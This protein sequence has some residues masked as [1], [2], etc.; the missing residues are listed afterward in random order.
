MLTNIVLGKMPAKSK[1]LPKP[2]GKVQEPEVGTAPGT[3]WGFDS[4]GNLRTHGPLEEPNSYANLGIL[5]S[6]TRGRSINEG[7]GVLYTLTTTLGTELKLGSKLFRPLLWE[8][9]CDE[10]DNMDPDSL[11]IVEGIDGFGPNEIVESLDGRTQRGVEGF[12]EGNEY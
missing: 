12:G 11:A 5:K 1:G 6:F 8:D 3:L 2:K 7:V 10:G 9:K 4:E